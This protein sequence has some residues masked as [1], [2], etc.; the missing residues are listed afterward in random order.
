MED[1][2]ERQDD[3]RNILTIMYKVRHRPSYIDEKPS[4]TKRQKT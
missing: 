3:E 4:F 2:T 1:T